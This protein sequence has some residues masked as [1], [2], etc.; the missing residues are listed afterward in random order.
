MAMPSAWIDHY[1][2]I[3]G[4]LWNQALARLDEYLAA[5]QKFEERRR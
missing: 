5:L 4:R 3:H 1:L 2:R